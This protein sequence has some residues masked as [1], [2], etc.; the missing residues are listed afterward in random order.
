MATH[1]LSPAPRLNF[2]HIV[3]LLLL[4]LLLVLLL[5]LLLLLLVILVR[6]LYRAGCAHCRARCRVWSWGLSRQTV[7][8]RPPMD[9]TT[10][11]RHKRCTAVFTPA[12][13]ARR[14][15][16]WGKPRPFV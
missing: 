16:G 14:D 4:L 11:R 7:S 15:A 6:L 3:R 12:T 5:L 9:H 8:I 1:I 13:A 2:P 10:R